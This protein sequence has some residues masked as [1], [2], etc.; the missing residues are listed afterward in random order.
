MAR[1]HDESLQHH[2]TV[3]SPENNLK[4]SN[5]LSRARPIARLLSVFIL[6]QQPGL[7]EPGS[8]NQSTRCSKASTLSLL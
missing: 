7:A 6:Q 2:V 1:A 4:G 3:L 8:S 5:F